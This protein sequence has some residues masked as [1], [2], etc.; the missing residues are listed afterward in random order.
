[1]PDRNRRT[2]GTQHPKCCSTTRTARTPNPTVA[3]AK[4]PA[5]G[6]DEA[7]PFR[8]GRPRI[9]ASRVSSMFAF[10]NRL[11]DPRPYVDR[12]P[13]RRRAQSNKY[14]NSDSFGM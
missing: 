11:G 3:K 8:L 5:E 9:L 13:I 2:L 6:S 12:R 1:M 7:D 10:T 14:L 4:R